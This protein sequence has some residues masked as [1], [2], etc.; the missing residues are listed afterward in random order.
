MQDKVDVIMKVA[1]LLF[2]L[3][4]V[5]MV[6]GFTFLYFMGF[7]MSFDAPGSAQDPKAWGTRFLIFL[8]IL[9]FGILL[10]VALIAFLA[11]NYKRSAVFSG[12]PIALGIILIGMVMVSSARSLVKYKEK[13]AQ[14]L[15]DE[16]LYPEQHYTRASPSGSGTDTI[17]VFP[18]RIVAYRL[19]TGNPYHWGGPIGDLDESRSTITYEVR[20][21]TKIAVEELE[22]F[23]DER[24]R[25]LTDVYEIKVD[26][27]PPLTRKID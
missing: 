8:P 25:K 2:M 19:Y 1:A 4:G 23:V 10:I 5:I 3:I 18:S 21:D 9:I 16:K 22:Q 6:L 24:G 7:V 11:G 12:I 13:R 27:N 14:E 26:P 20:T 17:I 15:R